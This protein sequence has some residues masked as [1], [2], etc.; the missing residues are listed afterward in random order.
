MLEKLI[1]LHPSDELYGADRILLEL[2]AALPEGVAAEVW[3]PSDLEH[4]D[5][6][7]CERLVRDGWV[8]RHMDMPIMRRAYQTPAGLVSLAPRAFRLWRDLRRA[9]PAFVYCTTSAAF[10]GA[11]I[12]RI[13]G[14]PRV[15]GHV[16]EIWSNADRLI[17]GGLAGCCHG[18]LV[19]SEAV[20]SA[21]PPALRERATTLVN[22]TPE[23]PSVT[24]LGAR[25]GPLTFL[26]ASRW[27]RW[28]GHG[29]LLHAW[30]LAGA[31]GNLVVLGGPP[32]SGDRVDVGNLV[33]E[34]DLSSS[35]TVV[36]EVADSSSHLAEADVVVM[37]S[38]EPEPFGLVAIEAFA[39]ARPVIASAGGG[40][41]EIVTPGENGWLFPPTDAHALAELLSSLTRPEVAAAGIRARATFEDRYTVERLASQWRAAVFGAVSPMPDGARRAARSGRG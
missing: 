10:L 23:P 26:V 20:R 12:A 36:G 29:T 3:L 13:A 19:I 16:Q 21:L 7:L 33:Q 34:L 15:Y 8:V 37:P 6:A 39:R 1:F 14:V 11:P 24:W 17:L 5:V 27:N 28:K 18:L 32:L 9:D 38:D 4:P 41:L 40:L 30:S 31:P 35:V 2:L 25:T 22:A